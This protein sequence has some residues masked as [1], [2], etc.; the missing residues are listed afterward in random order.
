MKADDQVKKLLEMFITK[1]A[2]TN[3]YDSGSFARALRNSKK[4][5]AMFEEEVWKDLNKVAELSLGAS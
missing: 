5:A 2:I 3:T 1:F 4:L